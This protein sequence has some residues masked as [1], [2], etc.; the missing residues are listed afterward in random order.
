[1]STLQEHLDDLAPTAPVRQFAT[2]LTRRTA[3]ESHRADDYVSLRPSMSGAIA[4]YAHRNRVSIALTPERAIAAVSRLPGATPEK[5]GPTTYL[6][7]SDDLLAQH[8]RAVLE[9]AVE[10]VA[11]KAAGPTSTLGGHIKQAQKFPQTCPE[12]SQPL[13]PSGVCWQCE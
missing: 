2:E 5:K 3:V 9:L 4:V 8:A 13:T 10:A 1:M 12:H 6:H 11:W 7:L